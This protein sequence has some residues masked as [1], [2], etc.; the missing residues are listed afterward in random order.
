MTTTTRGNS[1]CASLE[2]LYTFYWRVDASLNGA[3]FQI[4]F[5]HLANRGFQVQFTTNLLD[6]ASWQ[7]VLMP[8]NGLIFPAAPFRALIEDSITNAAGRFYRV[9]IL[10]P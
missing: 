8:G 3:A 1:T 2:A 6:S 7:P 5:D 9:Q 4:Q 10:E